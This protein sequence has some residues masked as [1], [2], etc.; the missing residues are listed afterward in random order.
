MKTMS[1]L[2]VLVLNSVEMAS[3]RVRG[4]WSVSGGDGLSWEGEDVALTWDLED[5]T[6]PFDDGELEPETDAEE[7]DLLLARVLDRQ[8]HPLRATLPEPAWHENAPRQRDAFNESASGQKL[9]LEVG[10]AHVP[11]ADDGAPSV[12]VLGWIRLL[13]FELEV[14]RLDPL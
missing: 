5:V 6:S 1:G 4:A 11:R 10:V 12:V 2:L 13:Y 8:H 14:G 9:K 7:R 3:L